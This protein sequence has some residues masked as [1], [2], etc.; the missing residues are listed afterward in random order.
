[1]RATVRGATVSTPIRLA[2]DLIVVGAGDSQINGRISNLTPGTGLFLRT[3][4]TA[5]TLRLQAAE[6]YSGPTV[7]DFG[8]T[9]TV[10]DQD[11]GI[12]RLSGSGSILNTTGFD[13]RS[14]GTLAIETVAS[15]VTN[16]VGDATPIVLRSG[17]LLA[18]SV[19]F[20]SAAQSE[21]VGP[22]S[23]A[24]FCTIA[25]QPP[26]TSW[27]TIRPFAIPDDEGM[28]TVRRRHC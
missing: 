13:V 11:A 3:N 28:G 8:L 12:L 22:V 2:T 14:G 4:T 20:G 1:L 7:V 26:A 5:P 27:R 9:T 16:R 21:V 17:R 19:S 15:G 24:G 18:Q 10:P 6:T 25:G 23:V